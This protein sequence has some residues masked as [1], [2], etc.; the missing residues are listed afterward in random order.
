MDIIRVRD[1]TAIRPRILLTG[2]AW[3]GKTS[4]VRKVVSRFPGKVTGFYTREVQERGMRVGFEIVTL[5]GK[6]AYLAHAGLSGPHRVGKFGVSLENLHRV[7]L[8]SIYASPGVDL[9]V[10]DEVNKMVCLSPR[11]I[12]ALERLWTAPVAILVTLAEPA[13]GYGEQMKRKM[14]K[15]LINVTPDNRDDLPGRI[16]EMLSQ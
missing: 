3:C 11:F 4:V 12:E 15:M 9:V 13:E 1:K 2:P 6:M 7:A 14:N 8:P 10:V 5:D 16:L